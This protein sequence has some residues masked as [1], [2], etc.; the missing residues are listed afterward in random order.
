MSDVSKNIKEADPKKLI[1]IERLKNEHATYVNQWRFRSTHNKTTNLEFFMNSGSLTGDDMLHQLMHVLA[2]CN[3]INVKVVGLCLDAGGSNSSLLTMLR[4]GEV[5]GSEARLTK[6][7]M[8]SFAD[9]NSDLE[10]HR[11]AMFHCATHNLKNVRNAFL[12]SSI[13]DSTTR[14]FETIAG[15]KF[16]WNDCIV[17]S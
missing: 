5:I 9:P 16:T 14:H 12:A 1:G 15:V 8:I 17:E 4:H 3:L 11:V 13:D 7:E 6:K 10:N 2:M